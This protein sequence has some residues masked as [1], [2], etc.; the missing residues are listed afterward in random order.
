M[1][2]PIRCVRAALT[3]VLDAAES[4]VLHVEEVL[5]RCVQIS[6]RVALLLARPLEMLRRLLVRIADA[7]DPGEEYTTPQ[8][9]EPGEE[10]FLLAR[11]F[12]QNACAFELSPWQEDVMRRVFRSEWA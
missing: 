4:G 9:F 10:D 12:I 7:L 8:V 3:F 11:D 5:A 1:S 2:H 6:D